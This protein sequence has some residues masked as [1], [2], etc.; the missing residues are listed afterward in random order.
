MLK[1]PIHLIEQV[2]FSS[3]DSHFKEYSIR[4]ADW[5]DQNGLLLYISIKGRN[6]LIIN[7]EWIPSPI[8]DDNPFVRWI[9]QDRIVLVQRRSGRF[10][11]NIFILNLTG[12]IMSSFH[13]GD[14]I[15]DIVVG[16]EG[17]WISYYYGG[18]RRGL[19]SEKLVLFGWDG[20]QIFKYETDLPEKPDILEILALVK[21]DESAIWL[22]PLLKPLVKIV[23]ESKSIA[24]YDEPD[25]LNKGAFAVS[26]RSDFV[27]FV[28]EDTKWAYACRIGEELAQP[29]GKIKGVSRGLAPSE[30]YNF[31]ASSGTWGEVKLYRIQNKEEYFLV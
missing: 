2:V 23:P 31:I 15:E 20:L 19:P 13:A 17:I 25:L 29:V 7:S 22:V 26:I 11:R 16:P 30:S 6:W 27:Y 5:Q 3:E 4:D 9:D 28:L 12:E 1:T 10:E 18:F 14:A 21:G 8:N 24:I